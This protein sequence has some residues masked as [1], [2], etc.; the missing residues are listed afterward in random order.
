MSD[1]ERQAQAL[2][3]GLDRELAAV[4][5]TAQARDRLLRSTAARSPNERRTAAPFRRWRPILALPLAGALVAAVIAAA[6]VVPGLLRT[7]PAPGVPA[8]GG[9]RVP[10]T[11]VPSDPVPSTSVP[12][13]PSVV[14][15]PASEQATE[16]STLR[17]EPSAGRSTL[18]PGPTAAAP[19]TSPPVEVTPG[20]P[21]TTSSPRRSAA[22]Q[23]TTS[24]TG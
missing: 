16:R 11:S 5:A 3:S 8:G 15:P 19:A 7:D 24:A 18:L 2:R 20:L 13:R 12:L 21:R 1:D 6:V 9:A 17:P 4:H 23:P 14:S 22:V 10:S